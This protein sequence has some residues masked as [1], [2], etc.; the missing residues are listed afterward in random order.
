MKF[1]TRF[2]IIVVVFKRLNAHASILLG[3]IIQ[4]M[5]QKLGELNKING[6]KT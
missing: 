1:D 4:K 5:N 6:N 3:A 2:I